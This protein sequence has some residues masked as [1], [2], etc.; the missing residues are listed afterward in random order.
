[1]R[2]RCLPLYLPK[3]EYDE[4]ARRA[5]EE[6]RD[7]LQQARYLLRR[8]LNSGVAQ[9]VCAQTEPIDGGAESE[10]PDG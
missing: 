7:P 9:P 5:L 6:E 4:L 8:A 3:D 10:R 1:M 2:S